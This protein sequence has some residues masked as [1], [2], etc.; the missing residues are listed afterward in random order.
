MRFTRLLLLC[1]A[2]LSPV[3][4]QDPLLAWM[5]RIAQEQLTKR[6]AAVAKIQTPADAERR[7]QW[8]RATLLDIIGG[9]PEYRGPLNARVLGRLENP[10]YTIEKVIFESLPK[11]YVTANLYRPNQ[12]GRY[13]AVL[14]S[15]GHTTLG[16]TEN[17]IMSAHLA[18]KGLVALAYDPVGLGER[19]QSYDR[20]ARKR[21]AGC[22]A[23]EHLHA[24]A[25]SLL[26][27]ESVARYFIH[28]AMR[29]I[30][31]LVSRPDVDPDRI[32]AAGCSGGGCVTTYVAALDSRVKAAA[33]ACFLN[34]LRV[35][36][37]GRFPDSEMSLPRF[38]ASGL[39]HAD[40]L[41]VSKG[42]PWLI[43]AT[44]EDF[45]TPAGV[46]PVY[47][48]A[49][50]WYR[51]FGSED[52]MQMFM[53]PG[54]HGTPLETRE[55]LY[56]FMIRW[57]QPGSGV[58]YREGNI[59]LYPDEE[60]QVTQAGQVEFEEGSRWLY[61]VI[62]DRSQLRKRPRGVP[63]L[64]AELRRLGVPSEGQPPAFTTT[65]QK[66]DRLRLTLESEPGVEIG[67]TLYL[68]GSEGRKPALLL[69]KDAATAQLAE[70]AAARGN[71]VL[72]LE[73]RDSPTANDNRP[74]LG[75]WLTNK[76]ADSIGRNLPA[77][78]AHDILRGVDYLH[79][80]NDVDGA[81]IR[82]AARN[83]EGV[84]LLLAAAADPRIGK[85][86][87]DRTP[88]SLS[89][90]LDGPIHTRLFDSVIP[91]FLLHWDFND[92][93]SAMGKRQV[94]WTD[95]SDWMLRTRHDLGARFRYREPGQTEEAL[96]AEF[97][98]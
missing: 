29:G 42:I 24:G 66:P 12:P 61:Q 5:D 96:L 55:K 8:I 17:H 48:E 73:P 31:Y 97:L 70:T 2:A 50:R 95:P 84:W 44:E 38:L 71:V 32:G 43:L 77:M 91:G 23:D 92:L 86:W 9:L 63:Q 53:G 69:V 10:H 19:V 21:T 30:D 1:T 47:E 27:G 65:E 62:R 4:A 20:N 82:A 75:N 49:R 64:L 37:A 6:D 88:H 36:F 22:C 15:A 57:L 89:A 16:K 40:F 35:L 25:Q 76:R 68:A 79:A 74:F 93:V 52:K 46:L 3:F 18:A 78:R 11:Y 33:P 85:I 39:D 45:F 67:A 60:L 98:Q 81:R 87:L 59:T 56:A 72:E 7:R 94:M 34:S 14:M 54:K 13:P 28:D 90:A 26:I 51:L 58:D 80:R 41:A 83:V